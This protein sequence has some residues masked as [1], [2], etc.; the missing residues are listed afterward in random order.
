MAMKVC[1]DACIFGAFIQAEN[2]LYVLDIG[3]GTGLL[4]LM[5]AQRFTDGHIDAIDIDAEAYI[6]AKENIA[7]SSWANRIKIFHRSIQE[8]RKNS[9]RKYDLIVS[10]PP[11]FSDHLKSG[12][13]QKNIAL[14]NDT[15]SSEDLIVS[16]KHFLSAHGMF[17]ILLPEWE[18]E[19]FDKLAQQEEFSLSRQLII[20]DNKNKKVIRI[21][22]GYQFTP[23]I[24][25]ISELIIKENSGAYTAEFRDLLKDFYLN[26]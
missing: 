10:N 22:S 12:N 5:L 25:Y 18:A 26:F 1:T 3:T 7:H 14:H 8:F 4:A 16:V 15:L 24:P 23:S 21:V 20:R 6:Q 9:S 13:R 11:F 17:Y 2:P 19:Q